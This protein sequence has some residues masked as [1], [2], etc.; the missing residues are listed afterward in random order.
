MLNLDDTAILKKTLPSSIAGDQTVQ[1]ISDS[2]QPQLNKACLDIAS[3]LLL[4]KLDTLPEDI[5]D[6]LAW[7]YHVDFYRDSFPL[8][9]KRK[10][11]RTA[12]ERHRR[13]GTPAAVEEIVRTV[14]KDSIV[15]EWF[16]YGG[17]PYWFRI[18]LTANTAAPLLSMNELLALVNEYKSFRSHLEG[19]YYHVP[20]DIVIGTSC[21]WICYRNRICGTYPFRSTL[22]KLNDVDIVI[23]THEGGVGY[24]TPRT[25][26]IVAGTFPQRSTHGNLSKEAMVI[27]TEN[28]AVG[29]RT[30]NADEAVTGTFPQW[31]TQGSI[32]GSVMK[33][34]APTGECTYSARYCGTT[35]G[36]LM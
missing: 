34:E 5:V 30:P 21:G 14:Y 1:D 2:I 31:A 8:A 6:S 29:Y 27:Y 33:A 4:P 23:E 19:V 17:E 24:S 15:E 9:T 20:H 11:V 25:N 28:D 22:G 26:E 32:D 10:L 12:I 7:Q 36:S 3:V 13:K 35:P 18:L 16:E